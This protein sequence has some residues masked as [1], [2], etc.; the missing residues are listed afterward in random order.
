VTF[1]RRVL[2][3]LLGAAVIVACE[4]PGLIPSGGVTGGGTPSVN[5]RTELALAME[6]EV[7]AVIAALTLKVPGVPPG[8]VAAACP[9][10]GP[11]G[12]NTDG[13]SIPTDQTATFANPPCTVTGLRPGTLGVT[14]TLRVRDSTDSDSVSYLLTLTD[15]AWAAVDTA[16]GTRSY[17]ATRN[18]TRSRTQFDSATVLT[19][20]L[21]ILRTRPGVANTTITLTSV[22]EF[23]TDSI[24]SPDTVQTNQALPEGTLTIT[25]SLHWHRSTENWDLAIATPTALHF[26]S[27]CTTTP[28]RIDA[29]VVT[30]TG[31]I[32][33]SDGVLSLTFTACGV[34]PT[35]SFVATP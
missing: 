12:G 18:G 34:D 23:T 14:G 33:G 6:D 7:E 10:L 15:L 27:T 1:N 17:T 3:L 30:L 16:G 35:G 11:N 4:T 22:S 2:P 32:S 25:G 5:Q 24:A 28:Q 8:F 29:G 31:S 13:D 21:T 9:T 19:S 20:D 26:D